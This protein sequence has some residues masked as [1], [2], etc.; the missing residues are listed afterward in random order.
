MARLPY[1]DP[2]RSSPEVREIIARN[3]VSFLRMLGHAD[4]AFESWLRYTGILLS[5]LELD[6][7]LRE[8]AILQ[9]SHLL[10]SEYPWVQHMAIARA[11]GASSEQIAAIA[12]GAD[13]D[14]SFD[15]VQREVLSFTRAVTIEGLASEQAVAALAARIGSRQVVELVLVIGHWNS[16]ATF[17]AAT[18]L[19]PDL[20]NMAAAMP[21]G[22]SG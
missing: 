7:L 18:G 22:L 11:V 16:I 5:D 21:V 13:A 19:E 8:L 20:P 2:D 14:S 1:V 15:D 12:A 6:P 3:P 17:V 4:S 10:G 9:I